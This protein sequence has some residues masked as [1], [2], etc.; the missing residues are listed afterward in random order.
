MLVFD[1]EIAIISFENTIAK[2]FLMAF[3]EHVKY[4]YPSISK[5]TEVLSLK[6]FVPSSLSVNT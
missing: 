2:N 6:I 4:N 3:S 1:S 5:K